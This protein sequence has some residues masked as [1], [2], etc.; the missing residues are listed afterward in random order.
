MIDPRRIVPPSG[1]LDAKIVFIGEAP[2]RE[3]ESQGRPFVGA[4]GH[5]LER[6][7]EK[8]GIN[9]HECYFTNV[10]KVRPPSNDF[11]SFYE[12]G[13]R[14]RVPSSLLSSSIS[15]LHT[16][17]QKL[18]PNVL[19]PLGSEPLRAVL[20]DRPGGI[21]AWRGSILSSPFGKV[22]GTFHPSYILRVYGDIP[23]FEHDLRR[24][25]EESLSPSI[26]VPNVH[27]SLEPS[28]RDVLE[29]LRSRPRRVSFDIET[30][31]GN[32]VRC[33]AFS[34]DGVHA[35]SIPFLANSS[36]R[37][38]ILHEGVL[39]LNPSNNN[40]SSFWS[41][42]EEYEILRE[43][44][45]FFRDRAVEKGAQN[46][47]F[48]MSVLGKEFG[49]NVYN[50]SIDTMLAHHTCY[51]ELPKGLD[52]LT[53]LYTKIPYYSNYD[54]SVDLQTWTYNCWDAVATFQV[55]ERLEKELADLNLSH[56]YRDQVH[57]S[58]LTFARVQNRG[59]RIDLTEHERQKI[60]LDIEI[61]DLTSKIRAYVGDEK[62]NPSSP[63]QVGQYLYGKLGLKEVLHHKTKN[64]TVGKDAMDKLA[65]ENPLQ[66]DLFDLIKE[67][68]SKETK[69][70]N[71][72]SLTFPE[73]RVFTS[74]NNAGTV[75]GRLASSAIFTH[76]LDS[77]N[78]QNISR[79]PDETRK[80]FIPD[81]GFLL[82][83]AD[84]SQA[85][86]R[87][88]LFFGQIHR[89]IQK[90]K[91]DPNYDVHTWLARLI[92]LRD[93]ILKTER[94]I[95]KNGVYGGNYMMHYQTASRTYKMELSMAKRVL[96]TYRKAVPEIPQ[97]W[98]EIRAQLS[99]SRVLVNPLGFRRMFFGRFDDELLRSALSHLPQSTVGGVI[100][101]AGALAEEIFDPLE[102]PL[103]LQVHD[104]L[105]WQCRED[106][107]GKYLPMI[108]R[109]ME[110]PLSFKGVPEPLIIPVEISAGKN[111]MECKKV[112]VL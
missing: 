48:D 1:P 103:L 18:R 25:R 82:V 38:G 90:Y 68:G 27:F 53:S 81:E 54:A 13:E 50:L 94:D 9:R 6:V 93:E 100:N 43:M 39:N 58:M 104:E 106:L 52:F 44:D 77:T 107:L 8:I 21:S 42:E 71:F 92:F 41:E 40:L 11:S 7:L 47:P 69:R 49:F 51:C 34:W 97:W 65:R 111:W 35:I 87:L 86:W 29:F 12:D 14:R 20:G 78:L 61:K 36:Q 19:V 89:M 32:F 56:Y 59:V 4:S 45:L 17:L 72:F 33:I 102:C 57:P 62:F 16:E 23:I 76:P 26:D 46:A 88:V 112:E 75:T 84:L 66:K 30:T 28:C 64:P 109:L 85:E 83:K 105:V 5:L 24:V 110:F 15:S 10:V 31:Y 80:C 91:E 99:S 101:R 108:K 55:W 2:G 74:F 79:P 60:K 70:S 63:K 3:E 67:H 22:C 95:A 98:E 37:G 73:G 96:D